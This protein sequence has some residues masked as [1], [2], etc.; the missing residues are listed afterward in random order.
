M[1][2][3]LWH[4]RMEG[5][6]LPEN[7]HLLRKGKYHCMTD[8]LFDWLGFSCF[9]YIELDRGIQVWSNLNQSNR[10]SAGSDTSSYKVSVLCIVILLQL[11]RD[12]NR[13]LMTVREATTLTSVPFHSRLN[14]VPL[15]LTR[16]EGSSLPK[17]QTNLVIVI[18]K[19]NSSPLDRYISLY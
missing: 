6:D 8:L 9:A 19:H 10:R 16:Y 15:Q 13:G 11:L 1:S 2:A 17:C 12:S 3:F 18:Y 14:L 7:T 4:N 5:S